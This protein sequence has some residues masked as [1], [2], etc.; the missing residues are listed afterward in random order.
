MGEFDC[1]YVFL[2]FT[3]LYYDLDICCDLKYEIIGT[4]GLGLKW[5]QT[6]KADS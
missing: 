6:N 3:S 1:R 2:L 4:N 5:T